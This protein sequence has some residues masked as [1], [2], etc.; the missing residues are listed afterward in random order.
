MIVSIQHSTMPSMAGAEPLLRL[1]AELE[2]VVRR[3]AAELRSSGGALA[4]GSLGARPNAAMALPF[5]AL[6]KQAVDE[7]LGYPA[8][9]RGGARGE[10]R[11]SRE[12]AV[13]RAAELAAEVEEGS[14]ELLHLGQPSWRQV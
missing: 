2:V 4:L 7:Y 10:L 5:A 1:A 9:G 13:A 11:G 12:A 14:W 3:L 6:L 8:G